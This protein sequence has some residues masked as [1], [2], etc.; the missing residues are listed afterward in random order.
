MPENT[1]VPKFVS[2]VAIAL[3]FLDLARGFIHTILLQFAASNIAGLDLSASN[4][5][6]LLQLMGVFG[7][8]NYLTGVMLILTGWKARPLALV[9]LGAIPLTYLV[10]MAGIRANSAPY[11]PSQAAWGGVQPMMVYLA[12]AAI[13]FLAG[14][15]VTLKRMREFQNT[16]K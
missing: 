3:G 14:A 6:D 13:T 11:A 1:A 10:G 16:G 2:I 4:A 15:I 12:A 8:S 9:M 7:I 5:A